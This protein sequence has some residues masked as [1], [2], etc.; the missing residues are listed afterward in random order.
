[1]ISEAVEFPISQPQPRPRLAEAKRVAPL[2]Q[3][4]CFIGVSPYLTE[5]KEFISLQATALQ[6]V[7]LIGE[8]GLRQEQIARALHLASEYRGQPFFA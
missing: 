2:P 5:L 8:R 3:F 1:M 6:P 7:L 4:D